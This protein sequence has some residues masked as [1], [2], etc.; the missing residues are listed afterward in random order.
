MGI[1][2]VKIPYVHVSKAPLF[3][4]CEISYVIRKT[5]ICSFYMQCLFFLIGIYVY[6]DFFEMLSMML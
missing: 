5:G 6:Y 2:K 4:I 1:V 3:S